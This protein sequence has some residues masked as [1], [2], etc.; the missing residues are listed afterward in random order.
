MVSEQSATSK[1]TL[2]EGVMDELGVRRGYGTRHHVQTV[3]FTI[4]W[5]TKK[6]SK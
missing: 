1:C 3:F 6:D 2:W 5:Q 4:F